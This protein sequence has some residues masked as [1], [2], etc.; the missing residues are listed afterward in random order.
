[1]KLLI[2][3]N[4]ESDGLYKA[5]CKPLPGCAADGRNPHEAI[6]NL[7]YAIRGYLAA[8]DHSTKLSMQ[9]KKLEKHR[10]KCIENGMVL[11]DA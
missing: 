11:A 5:L 2:E 4:N 7:R 3:V 6:R 9:A 1:M 8:V 10:A